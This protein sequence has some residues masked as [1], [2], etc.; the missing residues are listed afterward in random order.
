MIPETSSDP[1]GRA[2]KA[3]P[4]ACAVWAKTSTLLG[5]LRGVVRGSRAS[6][7]AIEI[8]EMLGASRINQVSKRWVGHLLAV[9]EGA[10]EMA[11][12]RAEGLDRRPRDYRLLVN[13]FV[14]RRCAGAASSPG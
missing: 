13:P 4:M 12:L 8:H 5:I 11:N 7:R 10:A 3:A 6:D 9:A 14:E 1:V 2:A